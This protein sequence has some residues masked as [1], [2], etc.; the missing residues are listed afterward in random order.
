M[1]RFTEHLEIHR[2][3][4]QIAAQELS[5]KLSKR[6]AAGPRSTTS[7][8]AAVPLLHDAGARS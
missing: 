3:L 4:M 2:A 7:N 6:T 1:S 8:P 5:K